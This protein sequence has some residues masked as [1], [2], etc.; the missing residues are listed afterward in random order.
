[1]VLEV[2]LLAGR[3]PI[4]LSFPSLPLA[5]LSLAFYARNVQATAEQVRLQEIV[6]A[7]AAHLA[8]LKNMRLVNSGSLSWKAHP[9]LA[10][11]M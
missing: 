11:L 10:G 1:M 6:A 5:P 8:S 7:C 9:L 2:N 3:V 4:A